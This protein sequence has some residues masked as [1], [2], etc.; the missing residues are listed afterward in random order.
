MKSKRT[1]RPS[2]AAYRRCRERCTERRTFNKNRTV[3]TI[4]TQHRKDCVVGEFYR[5]W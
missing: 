5:G 2:E 1:R 4:W 3:V